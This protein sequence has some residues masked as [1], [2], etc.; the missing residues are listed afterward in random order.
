M[1]KFV[2][3]TEDAQIKSLLFRGKSYVLIIKKIDLATVYATFSLMYAS[4]H[5]DINS[6]FLL[7]PLVNTNY[8]FLSRGK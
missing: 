7:R 6:I 4:G 3:I 5:P 1:G 2:K 8:H